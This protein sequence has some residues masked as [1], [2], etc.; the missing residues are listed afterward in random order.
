[1]SL[2]HK[3]HL[4]RVNAERVVGTLRAANLGP[5][6]LTQ[7]RAVEVSIR[8]WCFAR[9]IAIAKIYKKERKD[10]SKYSWLMFT[11]PCVSFPSRR[12]MWGFR[13][14]SLIPSEITPFV[15]FYDHVSGPCVFSLEHHRRF[16]SPPRLLSRLGSFRRYSYSKPR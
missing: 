8:D 5:H 3:N 10:H 16:T 14:T 1:V 2:T 9:L 6:P 15:R 7:R 12:R 11:T 13:G 4:I